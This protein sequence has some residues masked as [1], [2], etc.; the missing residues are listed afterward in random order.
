VERGWFRF[1]LGHFRCLAVSDGCLVSEPPEVPAEMLFA[2]APAGDVE[3]AIR[4]SGGATP[5]IQWTEEITCLLIDTGRQRILIDAGAGGLD[6]STGRLVENLAGAG[7]SPSDIDT[8]VVS[9]GHPDHIGGLVDAD[10]APVFPD[11]RVLLSKREWSF[12]MEGEAERRLPSDIV[13]FLNEFAAKT[14]PVLQSQLALV[15]GGDEVSDGVVCLPS[16][17]HTPGHLA[18]QL[19]S[20]GERLLYV[21]DALLHPLH[22]THPD[23]YSVFDTDPET[24]LRTR[25]ALCA[26]AADEACLVHAFHF[27]FPG[28]G[29]VARAGGGYAWSKGPQAAGPR[30]RGGCGSARR[31]GR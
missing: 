22:V 27:L 12:W 4:H 19:S 11:A 7:V 14:L 1:A 21:G 26:K 20:V 2:N 25:V 8:V 23:W 13:T 28:L 3:E 10:G 6:S 5:W 18:V 15:D 16:P 30:A 31:A 17:G 29:H 24:T 9:H